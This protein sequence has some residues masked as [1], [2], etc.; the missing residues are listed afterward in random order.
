MWESLADEVW[1]R[2]LLRSG[3]SE[4]DASALFL[5]GLAPLQI[6]AASCPDLGSV[7]YG[8]CAGKGRSGTG[9]AASPGMAAGDEESVYEDPIDDDTM[10]NGITPM[11]PGST[12]PLKALLPPPG[13]T[14]PMPPSRPPLAELPKPEWQVRLGPGDAG[15][16]KATSNPGAAR[17]PGVASAQVCS[18]S[19]VA[20][21]G[22][23][24]SQHQV[25]AAAGLGG[26]A[27]HAA[28]ATRQ[29]LQ[30]TASP[31]PEPDKEN[32]APP[33][34]S[35]RTG[36]SGGG[37]GKR[38]GSFDPVSKLSSA[39]LAGR[40]GGGIVP[41][42]P[43]GAAGSGSVFAAAVATRPRTARGR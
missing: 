1:E 5:E 11:P 27:T 7:G 16:K 41:S 22:L 34:V 17:K 4:G 12:G 36:C 30:V 23:R 35:L 33:E 19:A 32:A 24:M 42:T 9:L 37:A 28:T 20:G 2:L 29:A 39:T 26:P 15:G 18:A 43:A 31:Q 6:W 8:G 38:L 3:R 14:A 40:G 25:A 10:Q 13:S 21:S